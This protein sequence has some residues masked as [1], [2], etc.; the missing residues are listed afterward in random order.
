MALFTTPQPPIP[1]PPS[2]PKRIPNFLKW[3]IA[4]FTVLFVITLFLIFSPLTGSY[5]KGNTTISPTGAAGKEE[6]GIPPQPPCPSI[7]ILPA[8]PGKAVYNDTT[9]CY[10]FY[11][12]DIYRSAGSV[13]VDRDTDGDDI[14]STNSSVLFFWNQITPQKFAELTAAPAGSE[15]TGLTRDPDAKTY[16]VRNVSFGNAR[17]IMY[18]VETYAN[19]ETLAADTCTRYVILQTGNTLTT[20]QDRT[21]KDPPTSCRSVRKNYPV[22]ALD[23]MLDSLVVYRNK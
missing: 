7:T 2:S 1:Q 9:S 8:P 19:E 4:V 22:N 18:L 11:F 14:D 20:I 12:P 10:Y 3:G 15:V 21:E 13:L 17:G 5:S 16:K 6:A 23:T